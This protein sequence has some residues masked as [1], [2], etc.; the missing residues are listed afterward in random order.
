MYIKS[1]IIVAARAKMPRYQ[2]V[3]RKKERVI[4]RARG[5]GVAWPCVRVL[6]AL[7]VPVVAVAVVMPG[8]LR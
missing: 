4:I 1:G 5:I 3:V 2:Q 7:V 8:S 6:A